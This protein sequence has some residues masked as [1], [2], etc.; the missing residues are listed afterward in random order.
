MTQD[1]KKL[2]SK[3]DI[4]LNFGAPFILGALLVLLVSI[5]KNEI[6]NINTYLN[7]IFYTFET[8]GISLV[9]A[10]IFSYVSST[11]E[12]IGKIK[13]LLHDIVINRDFL[14]NIDNESKKEVLNRLIK[15][16]IAEKSVYR[17]I[18]SFIENFIPKILSITQKSVRSGYYVNATANL[19]K[20]SQEIYLDS[21]I[22][23]RLYPTSAGFK[24]IEIA[25]LA[26]E[27]RSKCNY[28][29]ITTPQ[30]KIKK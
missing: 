27:K 3:R 13:K 20:I 8:I 15:P 24:D 1:N 4:W 26:S 12:F 16:S 29:C 21:E 2:F 22:H 14:S 30:G 19:D 11:E 5:L 23:Y 10:S 6:N 18:E 25:F 9:V 7:S 28:I 17:N